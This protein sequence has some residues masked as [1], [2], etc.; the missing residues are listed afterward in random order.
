MAYTIM[1]VGSP[2]SWRN[3]KQGVVSLLGYRVAGIFPVA[4][5]RRA[6]F[7]PIILETPSNGKTRWW[8]LD[9]TITR[10]P[11]SARGARQYSTAACKAA[12]YL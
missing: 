5:L 11:F 2:M 10:Q 8:L 4:G 3:R 12:H 6:S 9:R 7:Q 1:L